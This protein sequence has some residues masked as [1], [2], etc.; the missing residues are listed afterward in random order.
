M[1]FGLLRGGCS[2][3]KGRAFWGCRGFASGKR[4]C[5]LERKCGFPYPFWACR[6]VLRR[7][8]R[9]AFWSKSVDFYAI[10]GLL[11]GGGVEKGQA[12]R[13]FRTVV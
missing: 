6:R 2:I 8:K 12:V 1:P 13:A 7:G 11:N 4:V 3:E 9:H 10:F 5:M